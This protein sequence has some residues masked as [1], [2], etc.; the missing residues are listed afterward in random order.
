MALDGYSSKLLEY[1]NVFLGPGVVYAVAIRHLGLVAVK[2]SNG[3]FVLHVLYVIPCLY[4][5][6]IPPV[7]MSIMLPS[8]RMVKMY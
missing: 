4:I 6:E 1:A 5:L 2:L 7:S 8:T 3:G